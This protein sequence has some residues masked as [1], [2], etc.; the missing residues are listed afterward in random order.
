MVGS[1]AE[2]EFAFGTSRVVKEAGSSVISS[3]NGAS[4]SEWAMMVSPVCCFIM[5]V[6]ACVLFAVDL[7]ILFNF[8]TAL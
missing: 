3:Q 5:P 8:H 7:S 1:V 4:N 6:G 2:K